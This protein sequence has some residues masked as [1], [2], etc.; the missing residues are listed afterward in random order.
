MCQS[1]ECGTRTLAIPF[2]VV[3]VVCIQEKKTERGGGG[4]NAPQVLQRDHQ[5]LWSG[6]A[7]PLSMSHMDSLEFT[8]SCWDLMLAALLSIWQGEASAALQQVIKGTD[9][10][11]DSLCRL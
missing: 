3:A 7:K 6:A 9:L 11:T 1:A 2:E 8:Q 5:K 10:F 4:G